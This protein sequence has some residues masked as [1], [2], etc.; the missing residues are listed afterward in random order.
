[1]KKVILILF[2]MFFFANVSFSEEVDYRQ[3]YMDMEVPTFSYVHGIDPGQ[4]YDNENAAYSIYPLFRLCSPLYFKT[5]TIQ[6]GYY[7]LTPRTYK[8]NEYLLF[9]EAGIVKYTIPVYQKEL[10][11]EG[12]YESHLPQ[13]RLTWQKRM[14]KNFYAFI[15]KHI[16]SAKRKPPVKTYLEVNDLDNNFLSIIV[17]F[18]NY[19][20]Y[21]IFRTVQM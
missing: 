8:G 21:T 17:Y 16:K 9:K 11:P 12:F 20:Y 4:Y 3:I 19:R 10:V 13:Q 18:G 1:M 15:G 2:L 6:P 14:S 7:D 5:I